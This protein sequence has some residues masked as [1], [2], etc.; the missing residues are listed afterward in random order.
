[1]AAA[2][3]P[4]DRG[5][6]KSSSPAA[7]V[8][9]EN[10]YAVVKDTQPEDRQLDSEAAASEDPQDVT[11]AQLNHLTLRQDTSAP[12]SSPSEEPPDEPSVYAALAIH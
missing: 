7:D 12:L 9:E 11:Y 6:Q 4:E 2:S 8:Q 10:L 1:M 5:L 3:E